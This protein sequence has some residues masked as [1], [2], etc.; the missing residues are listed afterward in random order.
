MEL[1]P[2]EDPGVGNR[3]LG[4]LA[5]AAAAVR[6]IRSFRSPHT[7]TTPGQVERAYKMYTTGDFIVSGESFNADGWGPT[8]VKFMSY[9]ANDLGEA[10]WSSIFSALHSFS[11]RTAK[12]EAILN[13]APEEPCERGA[14]PPSDPP[15][16]PSH[17]D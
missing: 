7:D 13:G 14:L 3:P 8:T 10:Q 12:E 5:L 15:S 4:I 17:D 9:I 16:P 1:P 11:A 6:Y 2:H